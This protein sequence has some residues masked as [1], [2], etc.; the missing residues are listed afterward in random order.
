MRTDEQ[1]DEMLHER[2]HAAGARWRAATDTAPPRLATP[3]LA[4]RRRWP[5]AVAAAASVAVIAGGLGW[6]AVDQNGTAPAASGPAVTGISWQLARW[7]GPDGAE[8]VPDPAAEVRIAHGRISGTDGCNALD[9]TARVGD[10]SLRV[11]QLSTTMMFCPGGQTQAAVIREVLSGAS[12]LRVA[13]GALT[14]SKDGAGSLTFRRRE[15][16]PPATDPA[17]LTANRWA[18]LAIQQGTGAAGSAA[19][20]PQPNEGVLAFDGADHLKLQ[21]N[22]GGAEVAVTVTAGRL[23]LA[24]PAQLPDCGSTAID[25]QLR[26]L[27]GRILT[28]AVTWSI[29]GDTLTITHPDVGVLSFTRL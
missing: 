23:V 18:L 15:V 27:L 5:R 3:D 9:G 17:A 26:A 12:R 7:A 25:G 11:G 2:L 16:V 14:I 24:A 13:S 28:G 21:D 22:C 1:L 4:R 19:G 8:H 29:S 10:G 6:L 20:F